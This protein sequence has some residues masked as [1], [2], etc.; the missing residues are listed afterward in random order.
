MKQKWI[1][2]VSL[3]ILILATNWT[4]WLCSINFSVGS[5]KSII[6]SQYIF[7]L[8]SVILRYLILFVII[9]LSWG[10][11][12]PQEE[13]K[14]NSFSLTEKDIKTSQHSHNKQIGFSYSNA[15]RKTF[16]TSLTNE[17]WIHFCNCRRRSNLS[18][19][20]LLSNEKYDNLVLEIQMAA[21]YFKLV[22]KNYQLD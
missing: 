9:R 18:V 13:K 1:I 17:F 20:R 7:Y 14:N 16:V 5:T 4:D 6:D 22:L 21:C 11:R 12:F 3:A 15:S 8:P 19:W 10:N 2:D